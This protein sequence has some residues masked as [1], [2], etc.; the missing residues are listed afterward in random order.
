MTLTTEE[1]PRIHVI[2]EE[3]G[4]A[5]IDV[6]GTITQISAPDIAG[7]M[8]QAVAY[9]VENVSAPAG[10]P[11]IV[12]AADP[13]GQSTL[14][15][16]PLGQVSVL[17]T[18]PRDEAAAPTTRREARQL[19]ARDFAESKAAAPTGPALLGWR[20]TLNRSSF[21]VFK[22]APGPHE[23]RIR[24]SRKSI[25][26]GIAGHKTI[27][28]IAEKGGAGK[29]TTT[30]LIGATLGRVRGGTIL[31]WDNNEYNGT[32]GDRAY[33]ASHD[34]TATTLLEHIDGFTSE[35]MS[36]DLVNFV[37]SQAENKFDVLASQNLDSNSDV[38]DEA[39][40]RKLH[41]A[42]LRFYRLMVVDTGNNSKAGTWQA[43][44][45][46][47]DQLV[48][49]TILRED[50]GR[51]LTSLADTLIKQ[52]HGDKLAN[53]VTIISHASEREYPELE[54]RLRN[55]MG[56]LTRAVVSVPFDKQL[57][58]GDTIEYDALTED[59]REAWLHA[60][61]TVMDGLERK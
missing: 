7:A 51:K 14:S 59:S 37:R 32:L 15:I 41:K 50:S 8:A 11:V 22:L 16:D 9:V 19:T 54:D 45:E 57:D 52:G 58:R 4:S 31:A 24:D 29:T 18:M 10:H 38:I 21:G 55:H 28:V 6:G 33:E 40:Y 60:T 17:A 35:S 47:A 39:A 42:L 3:N 30:Y 34:H 5:T 44:V 56:Q 13:S 49:V 26:R 46:S 53:A 36:A 43:A 12:T 61:A 1:V 27:A 23:Q 20:G 2:A 48:L 25:Q